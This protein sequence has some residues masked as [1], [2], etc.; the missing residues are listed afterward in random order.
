MNSTLDVIIESRVVCIVRTT[1]PQTAHDVA[2][3]VHAGGL[4]VVEISLNT[5]DAVEVIAGLSQTP[6]LCVGAGTVLSVQDVQRV[7]AAGAR[8]MVAP[9]LDDDVVRAAKDAGLVVGPGVFTGTECARALALGA[10]LLKLFPATTAGPATMQAL[11]DPF[12][13]ARWL[14]TGGIGIDNA[15]TWLAAGATAV[16]IGSQLTGFGTAEAERRAAE[17]VHMLRKSSRPTTEAGS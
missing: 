14:P 10:D 6:G 11:S 3:G 2:L 4:P 9:N 13:T 17:I 8:F 12:P 15:A 7:A 1:D 5:P 16:G